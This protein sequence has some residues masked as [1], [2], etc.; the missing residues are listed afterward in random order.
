MPKRSSKARRNGDENETAFRIVQEAT[1]SAPTVSRSAISQVMAEM[2]RKG[3]KKGGKRRL[4]TMTPEE[5]S[6]SALKAAKSRW[7]KPR[8]KP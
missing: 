2:G 7:S 8:K 6:Q 4:E 1:G 5:R 3:G